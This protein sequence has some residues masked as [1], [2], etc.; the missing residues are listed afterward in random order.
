[1][2][3]LVCRKTLRGFHVQSVFGKHIKQGPILLDACWMLAKGPSQRSRNFLKKLEKSPKS[4][5]LGLFSLVREAGLEF[6]F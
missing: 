4:F 1:M 3:C 2:V 5:D 6:N